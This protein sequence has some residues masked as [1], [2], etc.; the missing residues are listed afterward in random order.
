MNPVVISANRGP[1]RANK[2]WRIYEKESLE[3]HF[4]PVLDVNGEDGVSV[5]NAYNKY[6]DSVKYIRWYTDPELMTS[7]EY[8]G[9]LAPS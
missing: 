1:N 9:S 4:G 6:F 2:N 8:E 3:R 7:R 5:L